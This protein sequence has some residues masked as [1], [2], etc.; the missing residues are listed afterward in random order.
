MNTSYQNINHLLYP[1]PDPVF[2]F[3]G[4]HFTC[5]MDGSRSLGPNAVISLNRS[6]YKNHSI[7]I[8]DLNSII[9]FPGFGNLLDDIGVRD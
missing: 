3:L 1:V 6:D 7:N 5:H 2:P 9:T 8:G 4:I